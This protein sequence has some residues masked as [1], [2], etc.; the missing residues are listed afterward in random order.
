M[1]RTNRTLMMLAIPALLAGLAM[2]QNWT[3]LEIKHEGKTYLI[4]AIIIDP[5]HPEEPNEPVEPN[6]P[7]VEPNEPVFVAN[8]WV[9]GASGNDDNPGTQDYPW[10]TLDRAKINYEGM[11][12]VVYGDTVAVAPGEYGAFSLNKDDFEPWDNPNTEPL[13]ED[14]KWVRYVAT[15]PGAKLTGIRFSLGNDLRIVAHEFNGF[16]IFEPPSRG[17]YCRA[18]LGLRL[19]NM[20]IRGIRDETVLRNEVS[21]HTNMEFSY[22]NAEIHIEG[23]D[24][25]YGYRGVFFGGWNCNW[26]VVDCNI[27]KV[28]VDK[29]ITGGGVNIRIE[30]NR[31]HGNSLL[32][33]QHPDCI[34]FYTAANRYEGASADHVIIRGNRIYDHSS[35]GI[36]S[37]GSLLNNVLFENNLIFNTGNYEWRV[38]GVQGGIF[39][40]NTIVG[41]DVGNTGIVFYGGEFGDAGD[42]NGLLNGYPRNS[43]IVCRHNVFATSYSGSEAVLTEHHDNLYVRAW[44]GSPGDGEPNSVRFETI[45]EATAALFVDPDARD[46]RLKAPYTGRAGYERTE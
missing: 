46:Y 24:I 36:W 15:G 23:C 5:N 7:P 3:Q 19:K 14:Q 26:S 44:S 17:V 45:D 28:G 2:A 20:A 43:N 31:I 37:G 30:N 16:E 21:A 4:P 8:W 34:Q 1:R 12:R 39:Q 38:Y 41:D 35:Q 27:F 18:V 9:D 25:S 32:S 33:D 10:K 13:P 29:I 6:D 11:P 40:N 42:E 22:R